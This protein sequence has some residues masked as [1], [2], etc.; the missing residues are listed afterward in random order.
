MFGRVHQYN[1]MML[2]GLFI[3]D[4]ISLIVIG[5]YRFSISLCE[6]WYFVSF[7]EFRSLELFIVFLHYIFNELG[8]VVMIPLSF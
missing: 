1:H 2:S 8:S 5:L 7:K 4:S 3:I 6:F